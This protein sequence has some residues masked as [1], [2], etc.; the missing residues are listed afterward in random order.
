[1][2]T[3]CWNTELFPI[4]ACLTNMGIRVYLTVYFAFISGDRECE[5]DHFKCTNG[6]C[7]PDRWKCDGDNDCGDSSD[8]DDN[9]NCGKQQTKLDHVDCNHAWKNVEFWGSHS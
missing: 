4:R 3:I 7:I 5:G 6:H 8:E 2:L 1:M 9:L